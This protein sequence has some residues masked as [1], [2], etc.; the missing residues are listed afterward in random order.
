MIGKMEGRGGGQA[1][2][3]A[4]PKKDTTVRG[5]FW[6]TANRGERQNNYTRRIYVPLILSPGGSG[7][8]VSSSSLAELWVVRT[9]PA[10]VGYR[11]VIF[12]KKA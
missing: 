2:G 4:D 8:V 3:V 12:F 6:T 10:S 1:Q 5:K 11:L 9:K 7:L